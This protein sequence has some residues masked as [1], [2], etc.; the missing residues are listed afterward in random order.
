MRKVFSAI[1]LFTSL[2]FAAFSQEKSFNLSKNSVISLI[3]MEPSAEN[4]NRYGNSAIRIY[5]EENNID[6]LFNLGWYNDNQDLSYTLHSRFIEALN[7]DLLMYNRNWT[8]QELNLSTEEKRK[9][10]ELLILQCNGPYFGYKQNVT[11]ENSSIKIFS[12]LKLILS[13][14]IEYDFSSA[15]SRQII[16]NNYI[17]QGQLILNN[18]FFGS[19]SDSPLTVNDNCF[20]AEYLK[21]IV[22]SSKI[23]HNNDKTENLCINERSLVENQP[24]NL[25]LVNEF[26]VQIVIAIILLSVFIVTIIQINFEFRHN[27]HPALN[28]FM[29]SIDIILFTISGCCGVIIVINNFLSQDFIYQTNFNYVWLLP[30]NIIFALLILKTNKSL[31]TGLYFLLAFLCLI[32]PFACIKIWPQYIGITNILLISILGLRYFYQFILF[33]PF[34]TKKP[35]PDKEPVELEAE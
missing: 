13:D 17:N 14:R 8:E 2:L 29:K 10:F 31:L 20:T 34:K 24:Q 25:P 22:K 7:R 28:L 4:G 5:D 33:T 3:T 6:E 18:I 11:N 15:T 35:A 26:I 19:N 21:Q 23:K 16:N 30:L 32:I 9:V 12:L 1:V 27:A